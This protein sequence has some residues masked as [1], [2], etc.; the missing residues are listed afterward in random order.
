MDTFFHLFLCNSELHK[1][2]KTKIQELFLKGFSPLHMKAPPE[3]LCQHKPTQSLGPLCVTV[4]F[5]N[6]YIHF[7]NVRLV[8]TC[9]N[10]ALYDQI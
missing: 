5:R 10:M 7:G 8:F 1:Q 3:I 4:H 2:K 9:Q 6:K